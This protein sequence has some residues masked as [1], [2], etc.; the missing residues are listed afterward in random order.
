MQETR[1][2]S[3]ALEDSLEKE[4]ATHS[5]ILA[6]EIPQT[7]DPGGPQSMGSQ[8]NHSWLSDFKTSSIVGQSDSVLHIYIYSFSYSFPLWFITRYWIE[9]SVLFSRTL[10]LIHLYILVCIYSKLPIL[11][12]QLPPHLGNHKSV[13]YWQ[14]SLCS[15]LC[16]SLFA[17]MTSLA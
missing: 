1:V 17:Q 2:R 11:P 16:T 5:S 10:L 12:S 14:T 6:W 4:M 15:E 7:E 3:L 8:K 9:F 13:L